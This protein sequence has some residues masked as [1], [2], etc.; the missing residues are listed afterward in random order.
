MTMKS[1][2]RLYLPHSVVD[3][4]VKLRERDEKPA[5]KARHRAR[6]V[7]HMQLRLNED[8]YRALAQL[9]LDNDRS[10]QALMIE[11]ANDL[12]R[13]HGKAPVLEGPP[14]SD[15]DTIATIAV[16]RDR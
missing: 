15:A 1:N 13:K 8:G 10:L 16:M 4:W 2:A 11:A 14:A 5:G 12:L 6:T 3:E 9:A 7:R